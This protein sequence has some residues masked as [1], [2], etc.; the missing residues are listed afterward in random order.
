M[1]APGWFRMFPGRHKAVPYFDVSSLPTD[2]ERFSFTDSVC[3]YIYSWKMVLLCFPVCSGRRWAR[4]YFGKQWGDIVNPW[5]HHRV[6]PILLNEDLVTWFLMLYMKNEYRAERSLCDFVPRKPYNYLFF[7][8]LKYIPE[9]IGRNR[10]LGQ[11][12]I[13]KT[14]LVQFSCACTL[15]VFG[16][17]GYSEMTR[18][19]GRKSRS[20]SLERSGGRVS[21]LGKTR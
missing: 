3:V 1:F 12:R 2:F 17:L 16:L 4:Y 8:T 18:S 6:A 7:W 11:N 10:K 15:T 5:A 9:K 14:W 21:D 19:S 20:H 13:L